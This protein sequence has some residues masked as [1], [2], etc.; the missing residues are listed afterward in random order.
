MGPQGAR[1]GPDEVGEI[2]RG[3]T[4]LGL[5]GVRKILSFKTRQGTDRLNHFVHYTN[6]E[7]KGANV[8]VGRP[9]GRVFYSTEEKG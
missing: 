3:E 7:L 5:K 6:C 9:V 4:I 1:R 8:G 2:I